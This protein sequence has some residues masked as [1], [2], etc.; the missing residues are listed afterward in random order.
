[1][2][3]PICSSLWPLAVLSALSMLC[4]SLLWQPMSGS[5]SAGSYPGRR[6]R[7][8]SRNLAVGEAG[9]H[10]VRLL[11]E[12]LVA[13][14]GSWRSWD[15]VHPIGAASGCAWATLAPPAVYGREPIN[16]SICLRDSADLLASAI[17]KYGFWPECADLPEMLEHATDGNTAGALFVDAGANIGACSLHM[18]LASDASVIAFEPGADN[19]FYASSSLHRLNEQGTGAASTRAALVPVGLGR[20]ASRQ[21]LY[22]AIGNAGHAVIGSKPVQFAPLGHLSPQTV[23]IE[24]LDDVLWPASMRAEPPPPIALLKLDVEGFECEVL[25]GMARLLAAGAVR[26]IKVEVF[27][28]L[29]RLQGCSAAELHGLLLAAGFEVRLLKEGSSSSSS[30]AGGSDVR[31]GGGSS[32]SRL[33]TTAA[34]LLSPQLLASTQQPCNLWCVLRRSPPPPPEATSNLVPPPV[35]PGAT[36]PS[37]QPL[38]GGGQGDAYH[39]E[40]SSSLPWT[41][42][43]RRSGHRFRMSRRLMDAKHSEA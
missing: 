35:P 5:A 8:R 11:L 36:A 22:Q 15:W 37:L 27:D 28:T 34:P 17:R 42:G 9:D 43:R 10:Q 25:R 32:G 6:L 18:L 13:S 4:V 30:R 7:A 14:D 31:S 16:G 1:M 38:G 3:N 41:R 12:S 2:A 20:N 33:P 24:Q 21:L 29:L 23:L 39:D 40:A 19:L 26:A